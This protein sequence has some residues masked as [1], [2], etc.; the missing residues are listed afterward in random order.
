MKKTAPLSIA[1]TV[2]LFAVAIVVEAQQPTKIPRIGYVSGTGTATNQGPYVEALREGLRELGHVEGKTFLIEYRGAEG[3]IERVPNL[4]EE[5]VNLKVDLVVAPVPGAIRA[6]KQA[7]KTIP[8]VM[9][10][11]IDPVASGAVQSLARPGGNLT[12]ISTL[13]QDLNGKRLE[14]LKEVVPQLS[15][16]GILLDRGSSSAN[17]SVVNLKEYEDAARVLKMEIHSLEVQGPNPDLEA[18]F[19]TA[20]KLRIGGLIT[21]TN[22][23]ILMQQKRLADL[24]IKNRLPS[25]FSGST[26]VDSGG[27]MSYA[28]DELG[29]FRRAATYIDKIL[30][31]AKPADLPVEQTT[32]FE[33]VIN[34]KTAKQIGLTIP[35]W[36][37]VKANRVIK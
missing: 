19:K 1:V 16:L 8:I 35:Q 37:L 31:G 29:A 7:T 11:G 15:R 5:L 32:K 14:L 25:M 22:A 9:I 6:A 10:S 28:T 4:V 17:S 24:A 36:V 18:I 2:I 33:F 12:G 23:N 26:W 20:A 3:Q 30:K 27:L 21:I 34:L 13:A